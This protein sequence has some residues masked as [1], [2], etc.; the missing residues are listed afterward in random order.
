[1]SLV[2]LSSLYV[3]C[4]PHKYLIS[5]ENLSLREL[6]VS[7]D[8]D[9]KNIVDTL[10]HARSIRNNFSCTT[11]SGFK[12]FK[13]RINGRDYE[14]SVLV[15]KDQTAMVYIGQNRE[16]PEEITYHFANHYG[17]IYYCP[18]PLPLLPDSTENNSPDT[19]FLENGVLI[20]FN[21]NDN[22]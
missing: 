7:I 20:T 14:E 12:N 13:L 5:I 6:E 9:G 8:V 10:I 2:T 15:L 19:I 4:S 21:P 3:I 17:K 11:E 18:S 1:M 22:T 16:E